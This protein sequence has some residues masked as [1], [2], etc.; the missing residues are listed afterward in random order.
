MSE[1]V[2][3]RVA[4]VLALVACLGAGCRDGNRAHVPLWTVQ[5]AESI[6]SVRGLPVRVRHC[7]GTGTRERHENTRLYSRFE[8]LAAARAAFQ[9]YDTVAVLYVLHPLED[10]GPTS[11]YRLTNVRFI[12][13]P[14]VP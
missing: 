7:R 9:P 8:C 1:I 14:G 12:G 2:Q 4:V 6:T 13:G 10:D 11:R 3:R 5:Q